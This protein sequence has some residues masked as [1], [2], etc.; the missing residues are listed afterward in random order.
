MPN[1][2]WLEVSR[3]WFSGD[4]G[5]CHRLSKLVLRTALVLPV[6]VN[7]SNLQN[8]DIFSK[9]THKGIGKYHSQAGLAFNQPSQKPTI[10]HHKNL[11][12]K[13]AVSVASGLYHR[14][15][16]RQKPSVSVPAHLMNKCTSS[17]NWNSSKHLSIICCWWAG[18]FLY[19]LN[20]TNKNW[21]LF[22]LPQLKVM[23]ALC[24][25]S[26]HRRRPCSDVSNFYASCIVNNVCTWLHV[27]YF[28]ARYL[29]TYFIS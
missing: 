4:L 10:S 17:P 28:S 27:I 2:G 25:W 6:Q 22:R 9:K 19:Q 18:P 15:V 5:E 29:E 14:L 13:Q 8:S 12:Q 3:S 26:Q 20:L 16:S 7:V 21:H 1:L 24:M 23:H 11:L